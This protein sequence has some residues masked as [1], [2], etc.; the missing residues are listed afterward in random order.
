MTGTPVQFP[1]DG[2]RCPDRKPLWRRLRAT[3]GW[4]LIFGLVVSLAPPS[5]GAQDVLLWSYRG[6]ITS[7]GT[8]SEGFTATLSF[9]GKALPGALAEAV[10]PIGQFRFAPLNGALWASKGWLRT[11][12]LQT[13]PEATEPFAMEAPND[14]RWYRGGKKRSTPTDW[15]YLP[16]SGYW[17]NP[18][19]A[20]DFAKDILKASR[21]SDEM[22]GAHASA[23]HVFVYQQVMAGANTKNRGLRGTLFF[24]DKLVAGTGGL[25]TP[26]GTF[27]F[28]DGDLPWEDQGWFPTKDVETPDSGVSISADE[29]KLGRYSGPRKLGTPADWC[30]LAGDGSWISPQRLVSDAQLKPASP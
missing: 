1:T 19:S 6:E 2:S 24:N 23:Q 9:H 21:N 25:K 28:A 17:I 14:V 26:I 3:S 12:G 7:F 29:L 22:P 8:R 16:P 18:A 11:S 20:E 5:A 4:A 10:T 13:P 30:Y 15:I 27:K